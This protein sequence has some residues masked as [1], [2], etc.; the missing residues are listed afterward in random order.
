[1]SSA[2]RRA[3]GNWEGRHGREDLAELKATGG[4]SER[5][6]WRGAVLCPDHPARGRRLT[7]RV[8]H[9]GSDVALDAEDFPA[10]VTWTRTARACTR[11]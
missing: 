9:A 11:Y 1:M 6:R 8:R 7:S 4:L 2:V 5:H 3:R 10:I